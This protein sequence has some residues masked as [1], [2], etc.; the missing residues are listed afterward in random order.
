[1]PKTKE[2]NETNKQLGQRMD[3]YEKKIEEMSQAV[4]EQLN[5]LLK[6]LKN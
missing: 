3:N 1:M 4:L 2:L 5:A 6:S